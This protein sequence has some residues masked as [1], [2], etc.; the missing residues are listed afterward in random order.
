M[1]SWESIQVIFYWVVCSLHLE[2]QVVITL[3]KKKNPRL[4]ASIYDEYGTIEFPSACC[5]LELREVVYIMLHEIGHWE[6]IKATGWNAYCMKQNADPIE[7]ERRAE[8][9]AQDNYDLAMDAIMR[10]LLKPV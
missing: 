4:L 2:E 7:L 1:F 6:D 3:T 10:H 9:Y 5:K 8:K